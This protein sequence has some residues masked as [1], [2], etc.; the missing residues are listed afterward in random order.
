[1]K[2]KKGYMENLKL[3]AGLMVAAGAALYIFSE[4]KR[5]KKLKIIAD[6]GYETAHDIY[7][8]LKDRRQK[9]KL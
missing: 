9:R 8:P 7:F 6:A 3:A 1:M 5:R 2:I 4:I